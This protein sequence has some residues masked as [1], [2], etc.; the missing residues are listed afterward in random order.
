MCCS[1]MLHPVLFLLLFQIWCLLVGVGCWQN[2]HTIHFPLLSSCSLLRFSAVNV[3]FIFNASLSAIAPSSPMLVSACWCLLLAMSSIHPSSTLSL[4]SH[5]PGPVLSV[6]CLSSMPHSVHLL[7]LL[8][9]SWLLVCVGLRQCLQFIHF[10]LLTCCSLL[11]F[12][13]WSVVFVFNAS[14][15]ALVPSSPMSLAACL[16]WFVAMSSIHPFS[17]AYLLLT[18]QVQ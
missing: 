6:L 10:P 16:C 8:Q 11:R 9:C 4:F 14:L 2:L 17:L 15:S 3:V 18:S 5:L 12:N 13:D 7:L 1:S